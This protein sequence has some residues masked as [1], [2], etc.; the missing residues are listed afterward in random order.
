MDTACFCRS[1]ERAD[2]QPW[3]GGGSPLSQKSE[4]FDS[5]PRGRAKGCGGLCRGRLFRKCK[6]FGVFIALSFGV[7]YNIKKSLKGRAIGDEKYL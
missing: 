2:R 3:R 6:L 4:I 1:G 7:Y 5:S